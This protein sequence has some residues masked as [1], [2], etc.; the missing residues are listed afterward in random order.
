[1]FPTNSAFVIYFNIL[2]LYP[3]LGELYGVRGSCRS[4]LVSLGHGALRPAGAVPQVTRA[5]RAS[6]FR[7]WLGSAWLAMQRKKQQCHWKISP[8]LYSKCARFQSTTCKAPSPGGTSERAT[9][10]KGWLP[11]N[12]YNLLEIIQGAS[13]ISHELHGEVFFPPELRCLRHGNAAY[14]AHSSFK[15]AQVVPLTRTQ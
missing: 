4:R 12:Q 15:T 8:T 5:D 9:C 3:S 11:D 7:T 13:A 14:N 2:R 10:L 1:M 6:P